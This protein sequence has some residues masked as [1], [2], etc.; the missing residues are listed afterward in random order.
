MG[1]TWVRFDPWVGKIP[2]RRA[3]QPIPVLLA[4]RIPWTE[5]PGGLQSTG[6][7]RVGHWAQNKESR[8]F[9]SFPGPS[10]FNWWINCFSLLM[11]RDIKFTPFFSM[12]GLPQVLSNCERNAFHVGLV[13]C[14]L[15]ITPTSLLNGPHQVHALGHFSW[16]CVS[17]TWASSHT[18]SKF[19]LSPPRFLSW[20]VF[21]P[22]ILLCW[23]FSS[24]FWKMILFILVWAVLGL[25][26]LEGCFLVV[27]VMGSL[28]SCRART[29]RHVSF[30]YCQA[31]ALGGRASIVAARGLR[32]CS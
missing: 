13:D 23:C 25:C 31:H 10:I 19:L 4:W 26:C 12:P 27:V 17:V 24:F 28:S 29:S 18:G 9:P 14:V 2:W 8:G 11:L 5:E 30:S 7:P 21:L 20:A 22:S 1:E 16:V 32:N 3:W 15:T 6:S